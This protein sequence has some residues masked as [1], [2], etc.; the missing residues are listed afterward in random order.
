MV[1]TYSAK[2]VDSTMFIVY[3]T[4]DVQGHFNKTVLKLKKLLSELSACRWWEFF[5]SRKISGEIEMYMGFITMLVG[6]Y[7]I[8][9]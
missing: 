4:D 2:C 8:I 3:E 1:K 6:E 5:K 9:T 7:E